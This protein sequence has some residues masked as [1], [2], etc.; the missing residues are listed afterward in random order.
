MKAYMGST[1]HVGNKSGP[2]CLNQEL[3][4]LQK[5][6]VGTD[7]LK[8]VELGFLDKGD[9]SLGLLSAT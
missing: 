3:A 2:F 7:N 5:A 1:T 9:V 8:C 6:T 4:T